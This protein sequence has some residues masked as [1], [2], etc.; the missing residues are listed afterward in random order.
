MKRWENNVIPF[1]Q[2]GD[3][4]KCP[5][6]GSDNVEVMVHRFQRR[7]SIT[8]RCRDCKSGDHLDGFAPENEGI[9]DSGFVTEYF[10]KK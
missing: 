5:D 10:Q 7:Q 6:C 1:I 3:P 9:W 8:F 2:A 4:G